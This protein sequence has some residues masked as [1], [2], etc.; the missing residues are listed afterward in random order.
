MTLRWWRKKK[1]GYINEWQEEEEEK[2]RVTCMHKRAGGKGV[3]EVRAWIVKVVQYRIGICMWSLHTAPKLD[4]SKYIVL[5][6]AASEESRAV[7][8]INIRTLVSFVSFVNFVIPF[9]VLFHSFFAYPL[10]DLTSPECLLRLPR[11]K[12]KRRKFSR[13]ITAEW[14]SFITPVWIKLKK[15]KIKREERM[16]VSFIIRTL[17]GAKLGK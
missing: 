16:K 4:S 9:F 5:I 1:K 3:E 14:K 2:K 13:F 17:N 8:I 7:S 11:S 12:K 10:D 6:L 15:K